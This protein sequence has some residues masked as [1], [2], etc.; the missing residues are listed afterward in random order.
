MQIGVSVT[1]A[2]KL[3]IKVLKDGLSRKFTQLLKTEL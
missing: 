3:K 2:P 1:A